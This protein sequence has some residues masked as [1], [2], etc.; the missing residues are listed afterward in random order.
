MQSFAT[1]LMLFALLWV[2]A[3]AQN[4][5]TISAPE[6]LPVEL[7]SEIQSGSRRLN[8]TFIAL[9]RN[10]VTDE[11]VTELTFEDE[12]LEAVY[13]QML[14]STTAIVDSLLKV[15]PSFLSGSAWRKN[16]GSRIKDQ[17]CWAGLLNHELSKSQNQNPEAIFR[18][19]RFLNEFGYGDAYLRWQAI[20]WLMDNKATEEKEILQL[21]RPLK[22]MVSVYK[23]GKNA[24]PICSTFATASFKLMLLPEQ[25]ARRAM[26]EMEAAGI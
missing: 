12:E 11:I 6:R 22:R 10:P 4:P 19:S 14:V 18:Y 13:N 17:I 23:Q 21:L 8:Q 26:Q 16:E 7:L 2:E 25:R 1:L 20:K 3:S 15:Q 9:P 24:T 5:V